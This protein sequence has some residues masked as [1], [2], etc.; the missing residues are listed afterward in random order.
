MPQYRSFVPEGGLL[1]PGEF[2]MPRLGRLNMGPASPELMER[3]VARFRALFDAEIYVPKVLRVTSF[4][5]EVADCIHIV[6][7][8]KGTGAWK[9]DSFA[10]A[11][12][13]RLG[14]DLSG[15]EVI[16]ER[17]EG[18]GSRFSAELLKVTQRES[19]V[20]IGM[21]CYENNRRVLSH[22]M[23]IPASNNGRRITQC[24][25]MSA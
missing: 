20:Y 24:I 18:Y 25:I 9:F 7:L 1:P 5:K 12:A 2:Y 11:C 8:D 3:F 16:D 17:F 22:H 6:T 15:A 21:A 13:T 10:P 19:P 4:E 23:F 14:V